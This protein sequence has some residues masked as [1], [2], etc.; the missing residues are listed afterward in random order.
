[1]N[2]SE[3]IKEEAARWIPLRLE[4]LCSRLQETGAGAALL[5]SHGNLRYLAGY[6]APIEWG[7]SPF[8]P[9]SS[10]LILIPG[11]PPELLLAEGEALDP[12]P[13]GLV[14]SRFP[15]YT[16]REPTDTQAA[17]CTCVIER[18]RGISSTV[19]SVES[20]HLPGALLL[21][22]ERAIPQ[23]RAVDLSAELASTRA[24][25]DPAEIQILR[26]AVRLTDVGQSAARDAARAGISEIELFG[27]IRRAMEQAAGERLPILADL[28]S[29]SRS[30]EAGGSPGNRI[31]REG[32]MVIVDLA[33]RFK[34]MWGDSCNTLVIGH[35]T[36]AQNRLLDQVAEVLAGLIKQLHPGVKA[37]ELDA[38]GRAKIGDLGGA[39]EHHTGHGLGASW[40]E[41][42]RIVP[43][44]K[45]E[46]K[47]GMVVALEPAI[48]FEGQFGVR[49]ESV[50]LLTKDGA[51]V[52]TKFKHRP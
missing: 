29:G 36:S 32:E 34:G 2:L 23:L 24:I 40:H 27:E 38:F 47:P 30:A 4:R 7:V 45:M 48:Y 5:T 35:A 1:M 15:G 28:I 25:K 11:R 16:F 46:L 37:C 3:A 12:V 18:L 26:E 31:I 9:C 41:E 52:I 49:F 39:Y 22:L 44:N 19:V 42:P 33:P 50:M 20:A 21:E 43:Y 6:E 17:L 14:I 51:E 10:L 8:A 13:S